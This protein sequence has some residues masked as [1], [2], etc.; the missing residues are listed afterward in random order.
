[1][2]DQ[3]EKKVEMVILEGKEIEVKFESRELKAMLEQQECREK[4][5]MLVHVDLLA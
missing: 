1:M 3:W 5:V 2:Q 4:K